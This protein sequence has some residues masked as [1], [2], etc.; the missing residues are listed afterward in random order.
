LPIRY[1][2]S[3]V[4]LFLDYD[5]VLHPDPCRDPGLMFKQAPR[6]AQTL[7]AF[8]EVCIVLSTSWRTLRT[9]QEL[10]LPLPPALRARV[11]GVTPLFSEFTSPRR[12]VPYRRQAECEQWLLEHDQI[13]RPWVALDDRPSWFEPMLESLIDCDA[14]VGFDDMAA[15]RLRSALLRAR[16]RML[17]RLDCSV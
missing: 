16:M 3:D 8:P 6:L 9:E 1:P 17:Q 10:K 12:L 7:E 14:R 5:G 15:Q 11:I 2:Q 4:I 13:G